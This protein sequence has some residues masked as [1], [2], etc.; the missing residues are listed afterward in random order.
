MSHQGQLESLR[1]KL[2]EAGKT[3]CSLLVRVDVLAKAISLAAFTDF[4]D[5][6]WSSVGHPGPDHSN[7]YDVTAQASAHGEG[8]RAHLTGVE[9]GRVW[10]HLH[11]NRA[12]FRSEHSFW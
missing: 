7:G 11:S 6:S 3:C 2:F 4:K 1:Q 9:R 10:R 12:R 8:V 5:T